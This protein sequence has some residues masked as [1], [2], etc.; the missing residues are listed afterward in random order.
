MK[1]KSEKRIQEMKE[2]NRKEFEGIEVDGQF[3]PPTSSKSRF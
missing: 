1:E 3:Y 2:E